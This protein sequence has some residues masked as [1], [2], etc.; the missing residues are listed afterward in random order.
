MESLFELLE[1]GQSYWLDNLSREMI[2]DGSLARRVEVEG[3][4]G[5][6][7][8]PAIFHKAISGGS[9]YTDQIEALAG[10]GLS[11]AG[12]YEQLAVT[13]VR[14]A[15]D[16]LRPVWQE[17][18][19]VDGYVS[20][21]VSPHLVHDTEGSIDEAKR[22]WDAVDRPNLMVKIP[23]TPAGVSAIEELLFDGVNVNVTLLFSVSA[24]EAV[25]RAYL[26]ALIRRREAG[27]PLGTVASVASFFLSRIDVLV[28]GLLSQRI[29]R[30]NADSAGPASLFGTAAIASARL[31]YRSFES[32]LGRDEWTALVEAGARP[33]R[34]LWASTST[35][36]PLYDSVRYVE[37]LVGP[38]TV[39]TMPEVTIEAFSDRGRVLPGAIREGVE[40]A[41]R[42]FQRLAE[43]GIDMDAV[44]EQLVNE[45]ADKFI[46]PFDAL[47][48]GLAE[49]R[50]EALAERL[51]VAGWE[52]ESGD[53]IPTAL[54][55]AVSEQRCGVRL[56]AEDPSLWTD[57]PET[58]E[59]IRQRLGWIRAPQQALEDLYEIQ[60]FA[61]EVRAEG[62]EHVV[63]LG[64]GGS[65]LC[66]LVASETFGLVEGWP[67]LLVLDGVDPAAILSTMDR[68][69]PLNTLFL[70]ASKSGTT[71]ETISLY[72]H[73]YD[74][75][76]AAGDPRPGGRFVA[77]SDPG[78][79]LIAESRERGFRRA[80]ETPGDVGGR[81]SA[82][83]AFGLVP[84]A[85]A[86]Y[87]VEA[88]V[89]SALDMQADCA[90]EIPDARN[91]A[92]RLGMALASHRDAGRDKL[93]LVGSPGLAS[94]PLWIEQLVAEST[95][96]HGTGIVPVT[97]EPLADPAGY[98]PDRLFV[99]LSLADDRSPAEVA[100][101]EALAADGHPVLR[102]VLPRPEAIGGEFL[103]WEIATAVAGALLGVNPFD[104]PDVTASKS[105][106]REILDRTPA[107]SLP[108][109]GSPDAVSGGLEVHVDEDAVWSEGADRDDARVLLRDFVELARPQDYLAVLSFMASTPEREA[110]LQM[111]QSAL[112]QRTGA[113]ATASFGPRYLHSSGQ[114]HKGG[115]NTGV[116]LLLTSD[117]GHDIPIPESSHTFAALQRAQ[118]LGDERA[119]LD[120]GRRVLRVNLG[121][122][123]EEGLAE[124]IEAVV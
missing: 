23:G 55:A 35:K 98:G 101:A 91:P 59:R 94:L 106:T 108:E 6:T 81:F 50:R 72:R 15:C 100:R 36:N 78:S 115:P 34:L 29:D 57:D 46:V 95:G 58:A 63:V 21:E 39:N 70:V 37:P 8:N 92:I 26:D 22:L 53:G 88:I 105:I 124:L 43:F 76:V 121:W 99:F 11:V 75:V 65:S 90:P 69:D 16:V 60:R 114:L 93:T 102:I 104:E 51:P 82:L 83:T 84:M 28:D 25:H 68:I 116:Y 33:Q 56:A 119:L 7:S 1:H 48:A 103:R 97:H 3:L 30:R 123:V 52:G 9:L 96:K 109:S 118:A 45:G 5:V 87:D 32:V 18:D 10:E 74:L 47:I 110:L 4:R 17:S 19:G 31:A 79:E 71:I 67:E 89:E 27:R 117:A 13:D 120:R 66:S 49:R 61:A 14:E 113:P 62:T 122:Y 73:F 85:L 64:M 42:V 20:L 80:F 54:V 40:D 38:H 86:G 111:L 44:C 2:R 12:I 112:R 107:G 77:L 24:Y 41:Q